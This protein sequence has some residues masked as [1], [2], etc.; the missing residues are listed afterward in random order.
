MNIDE[1]R[2]NKFIELHQIIVFGIYSNSKTTCYKSS[3]YTERVLTHSTPQA[4]YG[5]G[6]SVLMLVW[7]KREF[8]NSR[9][10]VWGAVGFV[11]P[12]ALSMIKVK[13]LGACKHCACVTCVQ[14]SLGLRVVVV[15]LRG[16]FWLQR[17]NLSS[18]WPF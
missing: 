13:Q 10:T 5:L 2:I 6:K 3:C 18:N 12:I 14:V 11:R 7:I 8:S 9:S 1:T 15:C 4:A 16:Q 17:K